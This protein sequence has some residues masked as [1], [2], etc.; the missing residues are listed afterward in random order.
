LLEVLAALAIAALGV[1][2][3]VEAAG[4]GMSNADVAAQYAVATRLAQS[5]LAA[6]GIERPLSP[7]EH[8]GQDAGGYRWRS[9]VAP[10]L[11]GANLEDGARPNAALFAIEVAVSWRRGFVTR[12]VTLDTMRLGVTVKNNE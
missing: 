2:A 8:G 6:I 11:V 7:E 9:K 10:A 1:G 3:L 12:T 4:A 5:H